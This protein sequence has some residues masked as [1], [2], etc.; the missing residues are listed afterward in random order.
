VLNIDYAPTIV[1]AAGLTGAAG[2]D[3]RSL[4]PLL[5]G[6]PPADWRTAMYGEN[7]GSL[8]PLKEKWPPS[9]EFVET[10]AGDADGA[11]F[12]Y[13]E[14]CDRDAQVSPCPTTSTAFYDEH[15]DPDE[16]CNLL[17]PVGC[18]PAPPPG[19][20]Q[21]LA[22][23]L[24]SLQGAHPPAL[25]VT[26]PPPTSAA[27]VSVS[28]SGN[29]LSAF[30]CS[31]DDATPSACLSP[32]TPAGQSQGPH[33]LVVLGDGPAGTAAPVTVRWWN[34]DRIPATPSFTSTPPSPGGTDATFSFTDPSEPGATFRCALDGADAAACTSPFELEGLGLG[35]HTFSVSALDGAGNLSFP[36]A[37]DWTVQDDLTPP[38]LSMKKP[39]KDSLLS[40]RAVLS[41]W[42][43]TDD[44][45]GIDRYEA[46]EQVGLS[47]TPMI[48]QTGPG[49]S[50]A[51][52]GAASGT[53][54]FR[55][56]AF[57]REGNST[58]GP[59]RCA[60]V[61]LDDRALAFTG[62][63]TLVASSGAFDST[64]TRL[65]GA[66]S[67]SFTFTGRRLGVLFRK[68][69]DLGKAT[70]S[71][72]GGAAKTVDLYGSN[73]KALW[74][75]QAFGSS[76]P[77]TVRVGWTGQKNAQSTATDVAIDGVAAI[78]DAAPQPD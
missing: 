16:L 61:P 24:H 26:V 78:A 40:S 70:V 3:G 50:F 14:A 39:A 15:A 7:F 19:L 20:V 33:A 64:V 13:V 58:T 17:S 21:S 59:Q 48:V 11:G 68:G 8:S 35:H 69:P 74:W 76:G 30:R 1:A 10:F 2:M 22:S 27:P 56:T 23:R 18:G 54:C 5:S 25:A 45:S 34:S 72:D 53:Y 6:T 73:A 71:V 4:L 63:V 29:G 41:Q 57:D 37:F 52:T 67:T 66:G 60:A 36:A 77:H 38:T 62:P 28:F 31:E 46:T 65:T 75:T 32:F 44:Q 55:V 43:G 47:G 51:V 12:K 49:A 9:N 42:S